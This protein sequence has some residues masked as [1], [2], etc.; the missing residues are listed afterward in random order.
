MARSRHKTS[1]GEMSCAWDGAARGERP[2][3]TN[4]ERTRKRP[5][6]SEHSDD[7]DD[8]DDDGAGLRPI[9]A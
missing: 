7:D 6:E 4:D 2:R 3:G 1:I 8:N 5:P 9:F